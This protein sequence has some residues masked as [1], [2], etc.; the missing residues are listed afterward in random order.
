M[1]VTEADISR[2]APRAKAE[3]ILPIIA[4]LPAALATYAINTPLRFCHFIAQAAHETGGFTLLNEAGGSVYFERHYGSDTAV[5]RRLGN[6]QPGDGARY[7]G[8]GIFQL[9]GRA[10]YAVFGEK[11]GLNLISQP[12]LA[13]VPA[14]SLAIACLY[15]ASRGLNRFAD[16]DDVV[17][18]TRR[19][20]G[21]QN[22]L[23]ERKRYLV[24]AKAIWP[25][26]A[27]VAPPLPRPS[28]AN[29]TT[30]TDTLPPSVGETAD[31][32][33]MPTPPQPPLA[34]PPAEE[35]PMLDTLPAIATDAPPAM[36]PGDVVTNVTST[37][38][39]SGIGYT[40]GQAGDNAVW[41]L[42]GLAALVVILAIV[43]RKPIVEWISGARA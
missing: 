37:I 30:P 9:T 22:G 35:D 4:A 1:N 26:T 42:L 11:L 18:I 41:I 20:N 14:T 16:A 32:T 24:L 17:E 12:E 36:K 19:I 13:A 43:F 23:A 10:N 7:H 3:I 38:G 39:S 29:A 27:V 2:L 31:A 8:R 28:P 25:A 21:G 5:G 6:S 34:L 15:W 40:I 33:A